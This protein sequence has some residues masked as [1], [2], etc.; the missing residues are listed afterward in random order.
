MVVIPGLSVQLLYAYHTSLQL[1][2][3][4]SLVFITANGQLTMHMI[5]HAIAQGP[6]PHNRFWAVTVAESDLMP[7]ASAAEPTL[8]PFAPINAMAAD[9]HCFLSQCLQAA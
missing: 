9:D 3:V 2:G 8:A 5:N 7:R 1:L 4:H 6:A